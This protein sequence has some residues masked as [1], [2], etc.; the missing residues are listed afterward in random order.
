LWREDVS[1]VEEKDANRLRVR[2]S[3]IKAVGGQ[4]SVAFGHTKPQPE[5]KLDERLDFEKGVWKKTSD[6][7]RYIVQVFPLQD[8][9]ELRFP[10]ALPQ[11]GVVST[12]SGGPKL[13]LVYRIVPVLRTGPN[14]FKRP[15]EWE[16]VLV[17]VPDKPIRNVG[18]AARVSVNFSKRTMDVRGRE[19]GDTVSEPVRTF[20]LSEV[21]LV[22]ISQESSASFPGF[23]K[24][25][26]YAE[27]T[28][29]LA[30]LIASTEKK[31]ALN[32]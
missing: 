26:S 13:C 32:G 9:F 11:V 22:P 4:E 29:A 16:W 12:D 19:S 8:S 15:P 7:P 1:K 14:S 24:P 6:P 5:S 3:V 28:S 23:S 30:A 27:I 2:S 20:K 21:V 25:I 31:D 18:N 10:A 17:L